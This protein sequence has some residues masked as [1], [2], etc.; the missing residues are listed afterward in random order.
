MPAC[1]PQ[2][3][4]GS[5]G[6]RLHEMM[7]HQLLE[8]PVELAL[9]ADVDRIHRRLHV[10]VDAARRH[11]LEELE[12]LLVRVEDHLLRLAQIRAHERHAAMAEADL[13]HLHL[14]GHA[15][16]QHDLVAPVELVGLARRKAQRNERRRRALALAALPCP[17]VAAHGVIAARIPDEPQFLID[18]LERQMLA[19]RPL[20][21]LRKQLVEGFGVHRS[22]AVAA[23]DA[24]SAA[25]SGHRARREQCRAPS[26]AP[27]P[28]PGRSA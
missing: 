2:L 16:E 22:A 5:A 10:V 19:L 25:P 14:R 26:L 20:H 18:P 15:V 27:V 28:S 8:A 23:R 12:R 4:A 13:R 3:L 9:L 21:V 1:T 17:A 11:A 24:R 7:A 6:G